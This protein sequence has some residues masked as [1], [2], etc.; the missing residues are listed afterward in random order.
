MSKGMCGMHFIYVMSEQDKDKMI[1]LGYTLMKEDI[2]NFI[3]VFQNKDSEKFAINDE[4][5][6]AGIH[7]IPSNTLTF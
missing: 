7:F 1:A 5:S 6:K 3:W 2:R 4:M